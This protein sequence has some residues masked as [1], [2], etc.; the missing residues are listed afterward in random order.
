MTLVSAAAEKNIKSAM[1]PKEKKS[2][3]VRDRI[4]EIIENE[5]R[6]ASWHAAEDKEYWQALKEKLTEEV[7]EFNEAETVEEL[8]DVF[9]VITSILKQKEWTIEQVVDVQKKKREQ[10]G[11]FEKKIILDEA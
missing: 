6:E 7:A 11:A 3:L 2:K 10:R 8:A 4:V 9:E 1:E 5:G